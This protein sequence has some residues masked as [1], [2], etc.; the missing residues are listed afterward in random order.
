MCGNWWLPHEVFKLRYLFFFRLGDRLVGSA[1]MESHTE[2]CNPL[3]IHSGHVMITGVSQS[4]PKYTQ[5]ALW[6]KEPELVLPPALLQKSA[7]E[8][9]PIIWIDRIAKESN[10]RH[11]TEY[12]VTVNEEA[13][14]LARLNNW[15][16][17]NEARGDGCLVYLDI[18]MQ[19]CN[20]PALWTET[21]SN[22]DFISSINKTERGIIA[23]LRCL[24]CYSD[25]IVQCTGFMFPTSSKAGMVVMVTVTWEN[26]F[27]EVEV[28]PL[29]CEQVRT[30]V[31]SALR[32]MKQN[33][34][35]LLDKV[36]VD[37]L[38]RLS[39]ADI[40][41][42]MGE[43][44]QI[45]FQV[46]TIHSIVIATTQYVY[47]IPSTHSECFTLDRMH[48]LQQDGRPEETNSECYSGVVV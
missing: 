48:A 34:E 25:K 2:I 20:L 38:I 45:A 36:G 13:P 22:G 16:N 18:P 21:E 47:K 7:D 10:E 24:R 3:V 33:R 9:K 4:I 12:K 29:K 11:D 42:I 31:A 28:V 27:M 5:T 26:L 23:Q 17:K 6:A 1:S 37:C 40:R 43:S 19:G 30:S 14:G 39:D 41:L 46:Q 32:L 35:N 8:A 15:L 44:P